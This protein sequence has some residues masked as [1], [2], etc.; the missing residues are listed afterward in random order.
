MGIRQP[1]RTG[2]FFA[3]AKAGAEQQKEAR[4]TLKKP[5]ALGGAASVSTGMVA[6]TTGAQKTATGE[7]KT[8]TGNVL[9]NLKVNPNNLGTGVVTTIVGKDGVPGTDAAGTTP[10]VAPVPAVAGI[11]GPS[12]DLS[13]KTVVSGDSGDVGAVTASGQA[14]NNAI[15]EITNQLNAINDKISAAGAQDVAALTAERTRLNDLLKGYQDKL[16]KENLGQIAGP[17]AFETTAET[18]ARLLS[19]EGNNVG[20]LATIFGP[21]W[22]AQRYGGLSSQIYGK[23]LEAI[24]EEAG[25]AL[26]ESDRAKSEAGQSRKQYLEQIAANKKLFESDFSDEERRQELLKKTP[27]ELAGV[28]KDELVKL[29]GKN[30]DKL[31][32]FNADGTV[33]GTTLSSV[34]DAYGTASKNLEAEKLKIGAEEGK[35]QGVSDKEFEKIKGEAFGTLNKT[36]A[37]D[38]NINYLNQKLKAAEKELNRIDSTPKWRRA[39][40]DSTR[41][42]EARTASDVL[43]KGVA[44]LNKLKK[45]AESALGEK[46]KTK[47]LELQNQ[48]KKKS[49]ELQREVNQINKSKGF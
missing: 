1:T 23:D 37:I 15:T 13:G 30:A 9:T 35:A 42:W 18:T 2:T 21:R 31:F 39:S 20:K 40:G 32:T 28:K 29:F 41:A 27:L 4:E 8:E 14:V 36:G 44:E 33:K 43:R 45:D 24:Q 12:A 26:S 7:L 5:Q 22:N 16:T 34:K 48:I 38:N 19:E 49:D 6:N 25:A 10:A 3:Q 46:N 11:A 17:S 47:L